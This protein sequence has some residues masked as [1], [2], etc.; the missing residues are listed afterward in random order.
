MDPTGAWALLCGIATADGK[1]IDGHMQLYSIERKQQQLIGG[2]GGTFGQV[3]VD[4]SGKPATVVCF[5]KREKG[6]LQ[7]SLQINEIGMDWQ[8][9]GRRKHQVLGPHLEDWPKVLCLRQLAQGCLLPSFRQ[10]QS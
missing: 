3:L 1:T 6:S 9:Q 4:D 7:T 5:A 8:Q 2:H 10:S